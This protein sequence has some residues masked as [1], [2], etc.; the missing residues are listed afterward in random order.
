MIPFTIE[1]LPICE[2][3]AALT[4]NERFVASRAPHAAQEGRPG[5]PG[6]APWSSPPA[7]AYQ[8]ADSVKRR[9]EVLVG[10]IQDLVVH[11]LVVGV[12]ILSVLLEA[13]RCVDARNLGNP[14]FCQY[15]VRIS[16]T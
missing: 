8:R 4:P 11:H 14:V 5:L 15:L 9:V 12:W 16:V 6:A 13:A 7:S 1:G 3:D 2:C 10:P